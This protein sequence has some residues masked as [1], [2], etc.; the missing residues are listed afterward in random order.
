M[1]RMD[2]VVNGTR[3]VGEVEAN[4]WLLDFLRDELGLTGTKRSC[5]VQVCGSCTVLVDGR[6]VSS[7]TFLAH[8]VDGA[9]VETIEGIRES[10]FYQ[11][12]ESAFVRHAAV[13]C[14]FCTPGLVM[15]LKAIVED[16]EGADEAQLR[17]SLSG[18]LCRCTGYRSILDAA[19]EIVRES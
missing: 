4:V 8:E 19:A 17:R 11:D 15:T 5:D 6:P 14:G 1:I 16:G 2:T 13:Q 10:D 7:C 18:N 12:A 3:F 9:V